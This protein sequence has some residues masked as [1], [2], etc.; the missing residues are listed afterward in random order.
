MLHIEC[1]DG[2]R[3][4]RRTTELGVRQ[5]KSRRRKIAQL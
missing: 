1:D 5:I 4:V 3:A 2:L